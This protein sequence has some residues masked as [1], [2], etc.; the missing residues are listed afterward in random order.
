MG[1][2]WSFNHLSYFIPN[3]CFISCFVRLR[4]QLY[5][6]LLQIRQ[7]RPSPPSE[8]PV[9]TQV[10]IV[11]A[12]MPNE[13]VVDTLQ[14]MLP[15]RCSVISMS[16]VSFLFLFFFSNKEIG[17]IVFIP[18]SFISFKLY[19]WDIFSRDACKAV[20]GNCFSLIFAMR[21]FLFSCNYCLVSLKQN[22]PHASLIVTSEYIFLSALKNLFFWSSPRSPPYPT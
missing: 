17:W 14:R 9:D 2:S 6:T 5:V 15:V 20:M 4:Q 1:T 16:G 18:V 12:T 7:G 19:V 13:L 22:R 10:I 8:Q 3:H 21:R 11:G